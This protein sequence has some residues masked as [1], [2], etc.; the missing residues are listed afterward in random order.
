MQGAKTLVV[1]VGARPLLQPSP[2]APRRERGEEELAARD[3]GRR[4][5]GRK[6]TSA[7]GGRPRG[8]REGAEGARR[9]CGSAAAMNRLGWRWRAAKLAAEIGA[10]RGGET[11][12][13]EAD[14]PTRPGRP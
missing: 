6:P 3:G 8:R 7:A 9:P 13:L 10:P 5:H 11:A 1:S 4:R 12:A 2:R 14:F